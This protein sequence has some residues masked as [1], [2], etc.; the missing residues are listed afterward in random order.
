MQNEKNCYNC[1]LQSNDF[2]NTANAFLKSQKLLK[3]RKGK[4]KI[5]KLETRF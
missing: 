4:K 5:F 3:N 2:L 1:H